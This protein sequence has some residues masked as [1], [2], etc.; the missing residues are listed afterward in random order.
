[1]RALALFCLLVMTLNACGPLPRPFGRDEGDSGNKLARDI[2]FEGVEVQPLDGTTPPMGKLIAGQIIR[3]L[4]KTHEIPAAMT[5]FDGS[6]YLL[7]GTVVDNEGKPDAASLISI[8][9]TLASRTGEL[10]ESFTQNIETTRTE[11]DYGALPL[12]QQ[13]GKDISDRVAQRVLG[14][15]YGI[16]GQD[17]LLG[18]TALLIGEVNGAP[19]DGNASLRRAISVALGGGGVKLT[20]KPEEALFTL[21]GDVEMGAPDNNAQ[22]IRIL[23]LVK[24]ID[25]NELG[26]AEQS[27][28]VAAGSLDGRWG[29]TAAFVAAAASDGIR[30]VVERHDPTRLRGPDLGAPRKPRVLPPSSSSITRPLKQVPGRAPPPPG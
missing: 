24:D 8:D 19:G 23:W 10:V 14:D 25:G 18:R 15:R 21:T 4:E 17:R 5:G 26:R 16:A 9:W 7:T 2:F 13:I 20:N 27:N 12:L 1:M 22:K 30:A 28:M 29:R 3:G 11:W 6:Q